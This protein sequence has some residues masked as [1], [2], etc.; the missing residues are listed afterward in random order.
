MPVCGY[1]A[2]VLAGVTSN[3]T[4]SVPV[5]CTPWPRPSGLLVSQVGKP[6]ETLVC[7]PVSTQP[8]NQ[9]KSEATWLSGGPAGH[10]G[11]GVGRGASVLGCPHSCWSPEFCLGMRGGEAGVRAG[12]WGCWGPPQKTIHP[13]PSGSRS[14]AARSHGEA[15]GA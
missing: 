1:P 8:G 11:P 5:P 7:T 10:H 2:Q 12:P 9:D 4:G 6:A 3:S 14:L 15:D 13:H